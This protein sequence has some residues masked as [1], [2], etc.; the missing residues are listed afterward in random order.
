MRPT[1]QTK[2]RKKPEATKREP[3]EREREKA[4]LP[5]CAAGPTVMGWVANR[6]IHPVRGDTWSVKAGYKGSQRV[7]MGR[8]QG[9]RAFNSNCIVTIESN[10][11]VITPA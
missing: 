2:R 8:A 7:I 1:L 3:Q 6:R 9:K 4:G 10:R 5:R 11:F